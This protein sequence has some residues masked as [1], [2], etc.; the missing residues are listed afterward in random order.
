MNEPKSDFGNYDM[1]AHSEVTVFRGMAV[2]ITSRGEINQFHRI[3]DLNV[4]AHLNLTSTWLFIIFLT[5]RE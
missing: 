2:I 1:V 5:S 3:T 4:I